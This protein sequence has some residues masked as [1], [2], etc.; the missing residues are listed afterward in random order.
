MRARASALA[1][2][3]LTEAR[4]TKNRTPTDRVLDILEHVTFS[5]RSLGI[6]ELAARL[7][8]PKA[9]VYRILTTLEAR[10]YLS[11]HLLGP[12]FVPDAG[13]QQLSRGALDA[14]HYR[15][16]RHAILTEL[17]ETIG[18]ACNLVLF[19]GTEQVYIDRVETKWPLQFRLEVGSRVPVH[20]T[21]AGKLLLALQ[22]ATRQS[23]FVNR[24]QLVRYTRKTICDPDTLMRA[25]EDIAQFD[26]GVDDEEFLDGMVAV[27]VPLRI[28]AGPPRLAV[29]THAPVSR[30]RIDTLLHY[31]PDM[32]DAADRIARMMRK[33]VLERPQNDGSDQ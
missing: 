12:G 21:A 16:E 8:I 10:G 2:E 5:D 20:C 18:E 15:A 7:D 31:L 24:M 4:L 9:T 17:A 30:M 19:E 13:L 22:P 29:A 25:L 11:R 3:L 32:R 14:P 33:D 26:Y 27:A 28:G 1:S 23:G 6:S